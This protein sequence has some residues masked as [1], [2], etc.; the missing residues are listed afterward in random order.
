MFQT[1]IE[2]ERGGFPLR[3][4]S[5]SGSILM[6]GAVLLGL[7][8]VSLLASVGA[9]EP[10]PVPEEMLLIVHADLPKGDSLLAGGG[11]A[12]RPEPRPAPPPASQP[13]EPEQPR[14]VQPLPPDTAE[15]LVP[16][17]PSEIVPPVED[18]SG[19]LDP[20]MGPGG[21]GRGD[22]TGPGPGLIPGEYGVPDGRP[23]GR[24]SGGRDS[25]EDEILI[26]DG[27]VEPPI[28]IR[29]VEPEYPTIAKRAGIQGL[30]ILEGVIGTDG[31]VESLRAV[32]SIPVL[33]RAAISAVGQWLYTPARQH[34][35]LVKVYI[36]IR[37]EFRLD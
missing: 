3:G 7:A 30:V 25:G 2:C 33:D 19:P 1:L 5:V 20:E 32:R 22:G 35:R 23:G 24:G 4:G 29:R 10:P 37:V 9:G 15:P 17:A 13:P 14:D 8:S 6:H 36:T 26:I 27:S 16:E 12:A 21:H 34:G 31:R 11:G 28:A 18:G